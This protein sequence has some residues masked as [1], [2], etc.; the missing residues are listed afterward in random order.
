M[1]WDPETTVDDH[2]EIRFR[3]YFA[4]NP[5]YVNSDT[6]NPTMKYS[7]LYIRYEKRASNL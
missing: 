4:S 1:F 6:R 2:P 7:Y 3:V 5:N